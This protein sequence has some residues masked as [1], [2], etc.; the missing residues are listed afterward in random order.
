MNLKLSSVNVKHD[1]CHFRDLMV[2]TKNEKM[3]YALGF[4][5][6]FIQLSITLCRRTLPGIFLRIMGKLHTATYCILGKLKGN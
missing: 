6:T 2:F 1:Y 4:Q 3:N 5:K